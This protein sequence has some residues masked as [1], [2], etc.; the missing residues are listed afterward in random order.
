MLLILLCFQ[1]IGLSNGYEEGLA[2]VGKIVKK[3]RKLHDGE[4]KSTREKYE[5][6]E[7][8]I[9]VEFK[10]MGA[11]EQEGSSMQHSQSPRAAPTGELSMQACCRTLKEHQA[12]ETTS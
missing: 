8:P 6:L 2:H 9:I 10:K 5:K 11:L 3:W 1:I 12:L 7:D 4:L